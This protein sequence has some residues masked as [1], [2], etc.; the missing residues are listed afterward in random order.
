MRKKNTEPLSEILNQVLKRNS[1][2]RK[3]NEIRIIQAWPLVLG[4][5][6]MQYTTNLYFSNEKLFVSLSSSV[7]RHELFLSKERIITSLNEFV[8][9]EVVSEIIFQ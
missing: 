9:E 5:N 1:M 7:L 2:D 6:I 4:E 8:G 3:L